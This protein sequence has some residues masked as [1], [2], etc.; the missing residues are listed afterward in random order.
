MNSVEVNNETIFHDSK[1]FSGQGIRVS[2][3]GE[4]NQTGWDQPILQEVEF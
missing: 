3:E 4:E 2:S 1:K